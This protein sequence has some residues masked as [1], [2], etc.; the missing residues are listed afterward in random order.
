M[1]LFFK[2]T[3]HDKFNW[4]FAP[5]GE[6]PKKIGEQQKKIFVSDMQNY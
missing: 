1:M 5:L 4:T 3:L 6:V 2:N